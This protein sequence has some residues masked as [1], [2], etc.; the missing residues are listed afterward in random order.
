VDAL[1]T[2]DMLDKDGEL[3]HLA[4]VAIGSILSGQGCSVQHPAE[5]FV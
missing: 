5:S 2:E 4:T 3:H 1:V